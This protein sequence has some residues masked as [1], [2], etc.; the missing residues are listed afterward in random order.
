MFWFWLF[1]TFVSMAL[2]IVWLLRR[3][4]SQPPTRTAD[5]SPITSDESQPVHSKSFL[6]VHVVFV[7]DFEYASQ[8]Q[9]C[10]QARRYLLGMA[11]DSL[12]PA[13][14]G[15]RFRH[16]VVMAK[17]LREYQNRNSVIRRTCDSF[18][19]D[20]RD[21][22]SLDDVYAF[23]HRRVSAAMVHFAFG[24]K[25]GD[26]LVQSSAAFDR[27]S[28]SSWIGL[29][30]P[31]AA[32]W[33]TPAAAQ[34]SDAAKHERQRI[35]AAIRTGSGDFDDA[36]LTR[37]VDA[38][39]TADSPLTD[40][41]LISNALGIGI[42]GSD[43]TSSALTSVLWL[44]SQD[45]KVADRVAAEF[46]A[47]DT[48]ALWREADFEQKLP[49]TKRVV[50]EAVRTRPPFASLVPRFATEDFQLGAFQYRQ[51]NFFVVN[52][53]KVHAALAPLEIDVDRDT[54]AQSMAFGV[55]P[56]ACIAK[57]L[58]LR[59]LVAATAYI[60]GNFRV[61]SPVLQSDVDFTPRSGVQRP[62]KPLRLEFEQR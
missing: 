50:D 34:L 24:T 41:E 25:C 62:V 47:V 51:G 43:S 4:G 56:K 29:M 38:N 49:F 9:H 48:A 45:D 18:V 59:L 36:L 17:A 6:G 32:R 19:S 16:K 30:S 57:A 54:A 5:G 23:V 15:D 60:A 31:R 20:L 33:L 44:L 2:A 7:R 42:G 12:F 52:I 21:A 46:R 28:V 11:T 35:L 10:S 13:L 61:Q 40:A 22:N 55:G 1:A 37:M 26:V 39:A 58:A 27:A 14:E 3:F 53:T 8:L